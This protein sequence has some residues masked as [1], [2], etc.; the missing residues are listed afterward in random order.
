MQYA[1]D[2]LTFEKGVDTKNIL[3]ALARPLIAQS[4]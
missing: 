4:L 3:K 2:A 1:I